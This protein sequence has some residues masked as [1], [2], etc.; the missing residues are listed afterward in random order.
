VNPLAFLLGRFGG[1]VEFLAARHFALVGNLHV[2]TSAVITSTSNN[3]Y[4]GFGGEAGVR[5]Y[6]GAGTLY[7]LFLGP[8]LIAGWYTINY[9]GY[10]FQLPDIGFAFDVGGKARLGEHGF[11]TVG[12][13]MQHLSTRPY[14]LDIDGI[15]SFVI[16]SGWA[17]RLLLTIG[18]TFD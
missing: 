11:L 15:V 8:S 14:P 4:W 17:P 12:A 7:G 16:G 18:G 10:G 2:D 13:G 3:P 9:Y 1:D 5:V 6:P